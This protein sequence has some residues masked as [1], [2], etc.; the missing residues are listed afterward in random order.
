[1]ERIYSAR[2]RI[3][4]GL[5]GHGSIFVGGKWSRMGRQIGQNVKEVGSLGL[6]FQT[7]D[8]SSRHIPDT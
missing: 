2:E 7:L 5:R 8:P 3:G 4:Q 1:M 6:A